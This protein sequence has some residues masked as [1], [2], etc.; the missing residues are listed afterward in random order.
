MT[1]II[2][3]TPLKPSIQ[4][5]ERIAAMKGVAIEDLAPLYKTIDPDALNDLFQPQTDKSSGIGHVKFLYEGYTVVA[6]SD[7]QIKL[8]ERHT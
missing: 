1:D 3:Q 4:I 8:T 6:T 2:Q 5:A 7:G